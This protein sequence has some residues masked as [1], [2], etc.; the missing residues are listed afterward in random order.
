LNAAQK[1]VPAT[2]QGTKIVQKERN[3]KYFGKEVKGVK[4]VSRYAQQHDSLRYASLEVK[5]E[6]LV[7]CLR[8]SYW[9]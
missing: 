4:E 3:A 5:A 7:G 8:L 9:L 1:R 2:L 6:C